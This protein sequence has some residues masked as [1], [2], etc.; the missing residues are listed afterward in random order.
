MV[1]DKDVGH[2]YPFRS[3]ASLVHVTSKDESYSTSQ[4]MVSKF[5]PKT[6]KMTSMSLLPDMSL[7]EAFHALEFQGRYPFESL[8]N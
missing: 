2:T 1:V 3:L 7:R 4:V 5:A 6:V 8:L